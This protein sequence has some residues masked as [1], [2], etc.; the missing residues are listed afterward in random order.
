LLALPGER[1]MLLTFDQAKV[2]TQVHRIGRTAFACRLFNLRI[3]SLGVEFPSLG[4]QVHMHPA[5]DE[6]ENVTLMHCPPD[7]RVRV[8]VPLQVF[9]EE[10]CPG[11]KAGG[12]INWI[13]RTIACIAR[14]DSIP[15]G[16]EV[17]ISELVI[18]NKLHY[19]A[20]NIPE[21]VELAVKD[22]KL[23]ILKIMR[24]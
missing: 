5:T 15:S 9:G 20:L 11:L 7:R 10:V 14:G 17:D 18:G 21:G 16:F 3:D 4:R 22:P 12:R 8:K 24:K 23:P 6:I 19:D 13:Q 2:A 1:D